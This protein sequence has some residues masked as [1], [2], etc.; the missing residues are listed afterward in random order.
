MDTPSA[1]TRSKRVYDHC[2]SS[3]PENDVNNSPAKCSTR[4][5]LNFDALAYEVSVH[6]IFSKP[7]FAN[8]VLLTKV[9]HGQNNK[10]REVLLWCCV[11]H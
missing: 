5:K 11:H 3:S 7:P 2:F 8:S 1:R 10:Q 9:R 4:R 6:F